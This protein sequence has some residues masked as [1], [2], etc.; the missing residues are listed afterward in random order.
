MAYFTQPASAGI[1]AGNLDGEPYPRAM[2]EQSILDL[3]L[4]NAIR[5]LIEGGL[6]L[7]IVE[8]DGQLRYFVEDRELDADQIMASARLLGMKGLTPHANG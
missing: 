3:V 5:F 1:L 4:S 6:P 7:E 8:E 2:T